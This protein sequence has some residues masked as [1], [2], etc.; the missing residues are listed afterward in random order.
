MYVC[1]CV[2]SVRGDEG[3]VIYREGEMEKGEECYQY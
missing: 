3:C 1:V 2:L